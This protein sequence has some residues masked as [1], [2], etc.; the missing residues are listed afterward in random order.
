[1]GVAL[2]GLGIIS[3]VL[4]FCV[5]MEVRLLMTGSGFRA[6]TEDLRLELGN[7]LTLL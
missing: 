7:M 5:V 1:M 2:T 6:T 3:D 4:L